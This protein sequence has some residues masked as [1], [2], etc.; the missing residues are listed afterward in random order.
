MDTLGPNGAEGL[1]DPLDSRIIAPK[2]YILEF[3][4]FG[5]VD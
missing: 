4:Y 2:L 3:C 5:E 1:S